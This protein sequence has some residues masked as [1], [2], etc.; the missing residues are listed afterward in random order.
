MS[1]FN[2]KRKGFRV[3]RHLALKSN[4]FINA[5]LRRLNYNS[6]TDVKV[7]NV[8]IGILKSRGETP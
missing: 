2:G 1:A 5:K 4:A 8:C 3:S 6:Q 7:A